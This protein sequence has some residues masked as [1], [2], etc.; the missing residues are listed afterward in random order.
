[1]SKRKGAVII[2]F[3]GT[4]VEHE[5]PK[6]GEPF[7]EAFEVLKELKK[8]G[9]KLI[10]WTCREDDGEDPK[11][12]YL[13]E[14]VEFCRKN[15]VEFDAVN[16]SVPELEWR[17]ETSPNRKPYGHYHIDDR[18]LGGFVDWNVVRQV[19]LEGKTLKWSVE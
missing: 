8:A 15:G 14:A 19:I 13:T 4:L 10:L 3:D 6:I 11:T 18:N 2:D 1:M 16:E 5:F 17:P 9:W 12:Q 7:P